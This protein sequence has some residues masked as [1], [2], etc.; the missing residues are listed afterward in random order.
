VDVWLP[1][2]QLAI[3]IDGQGHHTKR[4]H[5]RTVA[6]QQDVDARFNTAA[7]AH[8]Q[9]VLRLRYS[10]T[11]KYKDCIQNAMSRAMSAQQHNQAPFCMSS[12]SMADPAP[13][14]SHAPVHTP[15]TPPEPQN[16]A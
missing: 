3:M 9:S 7:M 11:E 2:H 1:D 10:H 8:G 6:Q 13:P 14:C 5:A 4:F 12:S 15:M 16:T